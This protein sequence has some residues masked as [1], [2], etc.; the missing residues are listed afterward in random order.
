MKE[1]AKNFNN[2]IKKTL[3]KVKNKTN[4]NFKISNFN[5]EIVENFNNLIKKTIFKVKNKTNNNFK[6]SNFNKY[7]I[8]LIGLLFFYLFYLLLPLLYEKNWV[9]TNIE[10][11]L[12]SEF[13]IN[14]STSADISYR[15]LPAPHFLIKDSIILI[16]SDEKQKPIANIKTLKVFLSQANFFDKEKVDLKK[17][18]ISNANFSLLRSDSESLK[19]SS[20][21][22]FSNKKIEINSSNIFFKN[23]VD[24]I[25]SIVKINK[26]ILFFDEKK[27]LNFFNLK[28]ET[29]AVPFV[30]EFTSENNSIKNKKINFDAKSLNLNI[31]NKSAI[32]KDNL[33]NG[34]NIISFLNSS[35]I[36]K[37]NIKDKLII[38][39]S[40]N[41]RLKNF[42]FNYSGELS[43][44]PFDLKL[45]V[46]LGSH[47]IFKMNSIL[48]EFIKSGLLFNE[49][50]SVDISIATKSNVKSK[51]FQNTKINLNIVNGEINFDNTKF[52]NNKIGSLKVNNSNLFLENND[53]ILSTN[54]LVDIKNLDSF[55]SFLNTNKLSR[56]NIKSILI[57]LNYNF[58]TKQIEFNDIRVDKNKVSD[59]LMLL[60]EDFADNNFKNL[61]KS[62]VLINKLLN[63]YEG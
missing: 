58:S 13:K 48:I 38:F 19:A 57:N 63:A 15:I 16:K 62:R 12:R 23:N 37:Y 36:T 4:I 11:K 42:K 47:K 8:I 18:V 31:F 52:V 7:L 26:A 10:S 24:E 17:V 44:N 51:I 2:L 46:D 45:N 21:T 32:K 33:I 56:K 1:I 30:F 60:I 14:L 25:I 6:I 59:Q 5:K 20:D 29:F 43:I 9:Q 53:L 28:G 3:F 54:I 61:T 40:E 34:K 22:Q 55:Y 35:I 41:P 49:N 39:S 27:Q 50:I